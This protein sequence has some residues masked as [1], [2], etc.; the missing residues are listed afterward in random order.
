MKYDNLVKNTAFDVASFIA[1]IQDARIKNPH[2]S[3]RTAVGAIDFG[4]IS[5][6]E[7]MKR[8]AELDAKVS[9]AIFGYAE[10][11]RSRN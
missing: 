11:L 7:A 3:F 1:N 5:Q 9:D 4:D 6:E 2:A 10:E 8:I